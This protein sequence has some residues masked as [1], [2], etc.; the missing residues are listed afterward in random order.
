M[1]VIPHGVPEFLSS[2]QLAQARLG[3]ADRQ[4]ICTFGLI[5]RGK[6]LEYMIQAMPRIVAACPK[7]LYLIVGATHPQVKLREGETYRESLVQMAETLGVGAHVCFIN[8]Y[9]GLAEL[10]EHLQACDVYVTP[11]PGKDQISSGALAYALAAGGAVVS[12]PYLYAEEV[13]A[14]GRGLCAVWSKQRAGRGHATVPQRRRVPRGNAAASVPIC[15]AHVLAQ[16]GPAVFRVLRRG[17]GGKR[18]GPTVALS[19][20]FLRG[21][22]SANARR[23]RIRSR[24]VLEDLPVVSPP[25]GTSTKTGSTMQNV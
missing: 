22:R 6:G 5:N 21:E 1:R 24:L 20:G 17:R 25:Y 9:L 12:T 23:T 8:R 3:F 11:Y 10:L 15:E 7:A 14:N 2:R 19:Q 4:V 16:R 13:L 18:R